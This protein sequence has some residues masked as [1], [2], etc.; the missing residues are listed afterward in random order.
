M[1]SKNKAKYIKSLHDKKFRNEYEEFLVEWKKSL[2]ELLNSDF[3]ILD[4]FISK[5]F[6][7]SNRVLLNNVEFE[8]CEID[9]ITK[10]S[11]LKT[12]SDWIALVRQK[13]NKELQNNNSETILVLDEIKDPWNLW[14]IIRIADWYWIKKIIASNNTVEFYNPKVIISSM[15]SFCRTQIYYTD[16]KQYLEKQK[17]P[18][19]WAFLGW[20]DLHKTSLDSNSFLVIWNESNW[21]SSEIEKLVTKK[22]TIPRFGW[23]ESLNAWI[24][25]WIIIDNIKRFNWQ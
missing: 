6:F 10:V 24:A 21:I 2:E 14:T 5:D 12:N 16:L 15:W 13:Q 4:L 7:D 20:E 18:I 23:A 9:E 3:E 25:T 11:T 1:I 8:I 17:M 19:Y 22:I